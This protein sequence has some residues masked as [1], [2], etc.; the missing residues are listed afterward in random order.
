MF[1]FL[2]LIVLSFVFWLVFFDFCVF[3][4]GGEEEFIVGVVG[5]LVLEERVA[6]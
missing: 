5:G 6:L 2:F 1:E 4:L 3:F